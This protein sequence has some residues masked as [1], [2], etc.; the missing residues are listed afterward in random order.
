MTK[1]K[2]LDRDTVFAPYTTLCLSEA[3]FL[4]AAAHCK[5]TNPGEW[6]N[7][8]RHKAVVHTWEN[9]G[10]LCCVVCVHPDALKAEPIE[11][12]CSL[13]HESVHIFQRLCDSIVEDS[14]SRE[15]EAYSIERISERLMREFVRRTKP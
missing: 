7:E 12:A 4:K 15:F 1:L 9:D 10:K 3:E 8:S 13:V 11:V 2:W 5:I 14:P 6:M